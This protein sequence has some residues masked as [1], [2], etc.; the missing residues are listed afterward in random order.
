MQ[1]R[2]D[3]LIAEHD[4]RCY[5]KIA[6]NHVEL[7]CLNWYNEEKNIAELL[8]KYDG[9]V[10][11]GS[12]IESFADFPNKEKLKNLM[13]ECLNK[14]IPFLGICYGFQLLGNL[15]GAVSI[16][17]IPNEEFC[18][19]QVSLVKNELQDPILNEIPEKVDVCL[20]HNCRFTEPPQGVTALVTGEGVNLLQGFRVENTKHVYG[21]LFHPELNDIDMK[22]RMVEYNKRDLGY[23]F[24]HEEF[25]LFY[26]CPY[27]YKFVKNFF[28]NIV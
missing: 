13:L 25:L 5:Q 16:K 6:A 26:D 28:E 27:G 18:S 15:L 10:L 20:G 4:F 11:G 21:F 7:D 2:S 14:D 9:F 12:N 8:E 17:D 23:K 19:K 3:K 1:V 22:H 24:S